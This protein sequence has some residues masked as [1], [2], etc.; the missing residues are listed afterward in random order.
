MSRLLQQILGGQHSSDQI[1]EAAR[2][3]VFSEIENCYAALIDIDDAES[4]STVERTAMALRVAALHE[5]AAL[6]CWFSD[7]L[8][9]LDCDAAIVSWCAGGGTV[10]NSQMGGRLSKL[11]NYATQQALEP[12]AVHRLRVLDVAEQFTAQE[13]VCVS[14]L[15]AFTAYL[16]RIVA[17]LQL[18]RGL[19]G[20]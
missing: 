5:N 19:E 20:A 2:P 16:V 12:A 9:D 13:I 1:L 15:V 10:T 11:L 14:E 17:G 4:L 6:I 3:E 8:A 18:L 7:V